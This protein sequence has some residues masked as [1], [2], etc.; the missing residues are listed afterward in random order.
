MLKGNL[1]GQLTVPKIN[2]KRTEEKEPSSQHER[3]HQ[4]VSHKHRG[5]IP[6]EHKCGNA[7]NQCNSK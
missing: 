2:L 1:N 6:H 5:L 3:L 7:L 4:A